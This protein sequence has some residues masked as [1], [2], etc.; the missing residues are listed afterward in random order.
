[1]EHDQIISAD[2]MA[3]ED[4]L[5]RA[6]FAEQIVKSLRTFFGDQKESLVVG[7]SGK[8]GSGK[9]TLLDFIKKELDTLY[10]GNKDGY[11]VLT[12]NSW[13]HTAGEDL[14]RNFLETVVGAVSKLKWKQPAKAA[15]EKFKSYLKYLGYLKF[16]GHIHPV[17][18]SILDGADDYVNKIDVVSLEEIRLEANKQLE[19]SGIRLYILIDDLD[20]L[21]PEEI[22]MLFRILK[23]NLNLSNTI[24]I[25][26][27]DKQ[28]VIQALENQYGYEGERYM[29]KIIQI[30]FTIPE[31]SEGQIEQLFFEKMSVF[32]G[33]IEQP[34]D[35]TAF[36]SVWRI[37]GLKEYFRSIR[38]LN[39]YFNNLVFSLPNIAREVNLFDFLILDAIKTFDEEAYRKMYGHIIETMRIGIWEGVTLNEAFVNS[40]SRETTKALMQYLFLRKDTHNQ[41]VDVR[42][43]RERE[44]FE[45]YFALTITSRAVSDEQLEHFFLKGS[46]KGVVLAGAL[47]SGKM[48]EL[49]GRLSDK[50][51]MGAF[52]IDDWNIFGEYI[53][54]WRMGTESFTAAEGEL[55]VKSYFN[56]VR[57]F[58]DEY[59]ATATAV[60][61]LRLEKDKLDRI[62]F[63]F[64]HFMLIDNAGLDL[65][66]QVITHIELIEDRKKDELDE[67]LAGHYNA[68]FFRLQRGEAN[69]LDNHFITDLAFN[70]PHV[71][72]EEL[73]ERMSIKRLWF[74]ISNNLLVFKDGIPRK[75][76]IEN[77]AKYLPDDMLRAAIS[78]IKETDKAELREN[79][80]KDIVFFANV[81]EE[82]GL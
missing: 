25:V 63:M 15:N 41:V 9:S 5:G 11:K 34:F 60:Q 4:I 61:A 54:F 21:T 58:K 53:A 48:M 30:D 37:Y 32:M 1:M 49:L 10:S 45:R 71:Y 24:F 69:W 64:N 70:L 52:S 75:V 16:A 72:R 26:A 22:T 50:Q 43:L 79:E 51:L 8:W 20:R 76:L 62:G 27:Y 78:V 80:F 46:K 40:Y 18:K 82:M 33:K 59:K 23:V 44:Y 19:E 74:I 77:I 3:K 65:P 67:Y 36:R 57:L 28:V 17:L 38:D 14:E 81:V 39:R 68:H 2:A 73:S 56:L 12:F 6:A 42:R 66:S 13:A 47:S 29:E 55:I 35:S 31:I 7:I